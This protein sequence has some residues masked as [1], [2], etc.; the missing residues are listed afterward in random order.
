M[1]ARFCLSFVMC[2][3]LAVLTPVA[4]RAQDEQ[5]AKPAAQ[6]GESGEEQGGEI[7]F[8]R[9][10]A[11]ILVSRCVACHNDKKAQGD[12]ALHNWEA[13]QKG[14]DGEPLVEPGEPDFSLLVEVLAPDYQP[15][16]PYKEDPLPEEQRRLF[17]EWVRQG[18]KYDGP[19]PTIPFQILVAAGALYSA[20]PDVYPAALPITAVA[21]SPDGRLLATGGYHEILFWEVESG[22]L[23]KR[24]QGAPERLY[25]LAYSPNGWWLASAGGTPGQA[26]CVQLWDAQTGEP[27]REL[28]R[29]EDAVYALAFSPDSRFLAAGGTDNT[30]R[31]WDLARGQLRFTFSDHSD[32]VLGLAFSPDGRYLASASRD[33][34]AKAFDLQRGGGLG[35]FQ[36]HTEAV[37]AVQF[38]ADGKLV[39]SAGEDRLIRV[40]NVAD[41][42][43]QQ[44]QIGGHS[45][46]IF[47]LERLPDGTMA[48]C[49]A[50][51]SVRLFNPADGKILA[52]LTGHKDWVYALAVSRD[53]KLLATG[54]WDGEVRVWSVADRKVVRSFV[55][56]P[57]KENVKDV[58]VIPPEVVLEVAA[59]P[60]Q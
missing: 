39:C 15:R 28:V 2:A 32:W 47:R 57:T 37:Y 24:V 60:A 3:L 36:G 1:L 30:I 23:V 5:Q 53:G 14:V 6:T 17:E 19:S 12:V 49:S 9:D 21:F 58:A 42:P 10:I 7:S 41:Q 29:T 27:I 45:A 4:T 48:S 31:V 20:P 13:I 50:D 16:M 26:G 52:T 56:I 34:T 8:M 11:P 43:K 46:T 35:T 54:S 38:T 55:A 22:K 51:R 18:A 40:W 25:S 59:H 33:K 44:R